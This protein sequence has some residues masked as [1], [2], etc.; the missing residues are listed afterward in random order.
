MIVEDKEINIWKGINE[1]IFE[2]WIER[3]K[4]FKIKGESYFYSKYYS[5][6]FDNIFKPLMRD[7]KKYKDKHKS[8]KIPEF[9]YW[10]SIKYLPFL[11]II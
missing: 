4:D 1:Q 9:W 6:F 10:Y 3:L 8:C 5:I 11:K 2:S 7:F